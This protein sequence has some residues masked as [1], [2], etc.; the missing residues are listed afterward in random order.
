[1][2]E[3]TL[4]NL[5]HEDRTF[6][7]SEE[8]AAQA[9]GTADLYAAADADHE[10]FWAEQARSYVSWSKDFT[11]RSTGATRR[12]R[13]GSSAASSTRRTTA[14]TATSRPATAT[15]SPSTS[16]ASPGDTRDHH[17]RRPARARCSGRPTPCED[18]GVGKGDS[19]AIYL[20]MIP[21]AAVAMLACARIG[22]PHSVVFGGFSAEA[23]HTRIDDAEAQGRHHRRRRL[24]ARRARRPSSRP[25][26]RPSTTATRPV[27]HVLVV[28]A[29]RAGHRRGTT[30]TSGGTRRSRRPPTRTRPQAF[31]AEHPLFILYTSGTTGKPKGIFHTTGGYLDPGGLHERRRARRPPRD[32]RLLVHR[33]HRLGHR[34]L[35]HRLRTAGQRRDA[36]DVRGHA[37]H[38]APGPLVGDRPEVQGHDPL[39]GADR[40][41]HLHEVGRRH[42]GEVRPVARC[43]CSARSASRSTPRRGSGTASTSAATAPRS[44]TRGGRP[45]PARS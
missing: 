5:S 8:F 32:R 34:P 45:R 18:L 20:P 26:T 13:S 9:N 43:G 29:H 14:S 31:E 28:Q 42:P 25:S 2:S 17:V 3:E 38:P 10:G 39:H 30:A 4:S 36:G 24:P 16:S 27:E 21:E 22:A 40:D 41:P 35:L 6:P 33:R 44:S 19:V 12:S 15:R 23:L 37:G 1:M 7:P 11:R